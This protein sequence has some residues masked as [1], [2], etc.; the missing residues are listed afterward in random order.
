M[1][2]FIAVSILLP[3]F[4]N[5]CTRQD[6]TRQDD[7]ELISESQL[8]YIGQA[9]NQALDIVLKA[10]QNAPLTRAGG[11]PVAPDLSGLVSLLTPAGL[12]SEQVE[13]LRGMVVDLRD[14]GLDEYY[15]RTID[16]AGF[17]SGQL[18]VLT[19]LDEIM[20]DGDLSLVSLHNRLGALEDNISLLSEEEQL[21]LL[22]GLVVANH[23]LEYWK[24]DVEQW[25][26]TLTGT[27]IQDLLESSGYIA[28]KRIG[29]RDVRG[30]LVGGIVGAFVGPKGIIPG[31]IAGAAYES[32]MNIWRCLIVAEIYLSLR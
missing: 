32:L 14:I 3:L 26:Y 28:W 29:G 25:C 7:V 21:P 18:D 12:S 4:F 24:N 22:L 13:T 2:K 19:S 1:K 30:A 20:N 27:S 10:I 5:G 8:A 31:A 15:V 9:H 11:L 6:K 16:D 23:T 17:N